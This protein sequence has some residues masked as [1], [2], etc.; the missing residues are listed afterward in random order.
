M[1]SALPTHRLVRVIAADPMSHPIL[2][3]AAY[4]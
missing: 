4:H 3:D 1:G 2:F